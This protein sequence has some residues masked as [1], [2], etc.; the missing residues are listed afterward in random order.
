MGERFGP[1][2]PS[3]GLGGRWTTLQYFEESELQRRALALHLISL[4]VG[5][6]GVFVVG[7]NL[8]RD[9]DPRS[10]LLLGAAV[11][12][13]VGICQGLLRLGRVTLAAHT[14][15][16][17]VWA[18]TIA[19]TMAGGGVDSPGAGALSVTVLIAGLVIGARA[20]WLYALVN[21]LVLFAIY[22]AEIAGWLPSHSLAQG[23]YTAWTNR[24]AITIF[25]ALVLFVGLRVTET[26]LARLRRKDEAL[27]KS[28]R[29]YS[30][31]VRESPIGILALTESGVVASTNPAAE[32]ILG[33]SATEI[34]GW[35]LLSDL[36]SKYAAPQLAERLVGVFQGEPLVGEQ[37]DVECDDGQRRTVEVTAR[38]F[39]SEHSVQV[40]FSDVSDRVRQFERARAL[41]AQLRHT[42]RLESVG[43]LAG[44]IAHDFNNVLTVVL[45]SIELMKRQVTPGSP[46]SGHLDE[47]LLATQRASSL[48]RQLL[49]FS[50]RQILQPKHID[51]NQLVEQT[52]GMLRRVISENIQ[53]TVEKGATQATVHA[54]PGQLEQV[55][56][57]L[58]LN[59]R[60]AMPSG[61]SLYLGTA[62]VEVSEADAELLGLARAGSYVVCEVRDTGIGMDSATQLRVF[63]P[64]FTTKEP[65][66]GTGL[67]LSTTLGIV[68]QS[69]GTVALE[70]R[71]GD[72][73]AFRVYLPLSQELASY[74]PPAGHTEPVRGN[75]TILLAEDDDLVRRIAS[76]VL[77]AAGYRV[78]VA[79][80]GL[81]A[82]SLGEQY[83]AQIQLLV[84]DAIMPEMNGR[85]LMAR[86]LAKRPDLR[87]LVISG[88]ADEAIEAAAAEL[89]SVSFLQ[90]PFTPDTLTA[91]VREVLDRE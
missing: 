84:T 81:E 64:F 8:A 62:N 75:E 88:Y 22:R 37:F 69:G 48:T 17:G 27:V 71:P 40:L 63:D 19:A 39:G 74:R 13:F 72:G 2:Q 7:A 54:D 82:L 33:R 50:R 3:A 47:V 77:D 41:E 16:A 61:G 26:T 1:G 10:R 83:L 11:L 55:L 60:D 73:S 38:A 45:A 35:N 6:L 66:K 34:A 32:R 44:G 65:G 12:G 70:S 28:E 51:L 89:H 87:I 58:A 80:N 14:F 91:K 36:R 5:A 43:L 46:L 42:Q 24:T 29:R 21:V 23:P 49:A 20:L 52:H 90:K 57:N 4:V 56:I 15:T 31:L 59:A 78:L 25:L 76:N 79:R 9:P 85:E 86:L 30:E 53:M 67:G 18:T 68:R